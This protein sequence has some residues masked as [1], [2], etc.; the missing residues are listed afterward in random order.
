MQ[1]STKKRTKYLF[2]YLELAGYVAACLE[3][4]A[5]DPSAEVHLVRYPVNPVAPFRFSFGDNLRVYERKEMSEVELIR[6]YD[7]ID[8]DVLFVCGWADKGYVKVAKHAKK[9]I[10]VI[11]AFDNPW[12]GTL[13]QHIATVAGPLYLH[14][15]F[16]HCWVPG[17]PNA[18]Y[19]RKLGFGE[20]LFTGMYSADTSLFKSYYDM[21]RSE[22]EVA[23]PHRFI[24]VGRY[25]LLKG[26]R[27]LWQAFTSLSTSEMRDWELWCLGKG[28]LEHELPD[29]P[30]IKNF[31]FVQPSALADYL[32]KTGVFLLPAHYEHWG[33]VVHEFAAAGFPLI[34]SKMTS[35]ATTF[36]HENENGFFTEPKSTASVR[37]TL[38]R[39]IN[40]SDEKLIAMGRR[41]VELSE[42]ISPSTWAGVLRKI[43][44]N[45]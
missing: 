36:L 40:M 42:Q 1:S 7:Q 2:L 27:E 28:E 31:G 16:T 37:D 10:P 12:L 33:V 21:Y 18:R 30:R 41:S 5:S 19:A 34:C 43:A 22:K 11:L 17:E 44:N 26:V 38:L 20:K 9:K 23:F 45:N 24:F 25:T 4:L 35:A 14:R 6:L 15:I 13:K 39:T 32:R 8:P 29:H 3:E